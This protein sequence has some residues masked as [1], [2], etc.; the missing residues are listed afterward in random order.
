LGPS[1]GQNPS[2]VAFYADPSREFSEILSRNFS[3]PRFFRTP[4]PLRLHAAA[5]PTLSKTK[6]KASVPFRDER[7]VMG[8]SSGKN[9]ITTNAVEVGGEAS[10][11]LEAAQKLPRSCLEAA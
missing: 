2:D 8:L 11:C 6:L 1:W 10:S 3:R 9:F 4:L 7:P 5:A